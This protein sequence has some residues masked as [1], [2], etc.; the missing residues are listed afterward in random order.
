MADDVMFMS[1]DVAK[2]PPLTNAQRRQ[3]IDDTEPSVVGVSWPP[4][5]CQDA[6]RVQMA[7][8]TEKEKAVATIDYS[9]Q[10]GRHEEVVGLE[11]LMTTMLQRYVG[12]HDGK[13]P[14]EFV[15]ASYRRANCRALRH[16]PRRRV[17]R[18]VRDGALERGAAHR[19]GHQ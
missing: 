4:R 14:S 7:A 3:G 18:R 19:G 5:A 2:A 15:R 8:T 17:G 1:Y 9:L 10:P 13:Y 6:V 12:S 11:E 16:L